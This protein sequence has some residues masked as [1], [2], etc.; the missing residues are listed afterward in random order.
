MGFPVIDNFCNLGFMTLPFERE[1]HLKLMTT[2]I[3]YIDQFS[4]WPAFY[5]Q[6]KLSLIGGT[7]SYCE[8]YC[9]NYPVGARRMNVRGAGVFDSIIMGTYIT[10]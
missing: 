10:L 2:F 6:N 9:Y 1:S 4:D 3:V 7:L 5:Q 8:V